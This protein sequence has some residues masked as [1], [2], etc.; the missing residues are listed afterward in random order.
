M[1]IPL[2]LNDIYL[3]LA[4]LSNDNKKW[5]V[6]R[7]IMDVSHST[8]KS[9]EFPQIPKDRPVSKEV[10]D[11]VVG[12]LLYF[13]QLHLAFYASCVTSEAAVRA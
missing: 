6:E 7:L 13:K 12:T 3:M 4:G 11:M 10:L 1:N 5:L 2:S 8:T 9:I